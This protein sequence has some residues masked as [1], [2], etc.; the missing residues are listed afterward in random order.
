MKK[1]FYV[2]ILSSVFSCKP[3]LKNPKPSAGDAD[4][5]KF[6]ALGGNFMAG[7]QDWSLNKAGQTYSIP[8]LLAVEFQLAGG[9]I[10]SQPLMPDNSG[11]GLDS[12]TWEHK[13]LKSAYLNYAADCKGVTS[14]MPIVNSFPISSGGIYTAYIGGN[15]QNLSVPF[16]K[17]SDYSSKSFG[18]SG[19]ANP[20][21]ARFAF[22]PGASTMISDAKSLQP[23]FFALWAGME[24]IY[25]SVSVGG[26]KKPIPSS[27]LFSIKL[28]SIL[29]Q[30]NTKGVI[31][32]IPDVSSFPFYTTIPWNGMA[33]TRVLKDSLNMLYF[34]DSL[35]SKNKAL[36]IGNNGFMIADPQDTSHPITGYRQ[37]TNEDYILL[38]VPLD[39]M[40]CHYLGVFTFLP[41][42]YVLTKSEV[43]NINQAI[44]DYN[45][46]I[47]AKAQKYNLAL[48]D[49]NSY[50]KNVV[51]GIKWDG[52]NFNS[53]FVSGGFFSLDGYSPN[54]KGYALIANE[55][56]KAINSKY[57]A[58]IPW[59]NCPECSGVKFP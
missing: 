14:L 26:F 45:T 42:K 31:A 28:D 6:V 30:L 15:F 35:Y 3:N 27:S 1:V 36:H 38:T 9:R 19:N 13:F 29:S 53:Q 24:D 39:S 12:K 51:S 56:I 55:F 20:Y 54:Q 40:K 52:V 33:L 59:V 11:I 43:Q 18:I 44:S 21:Y 23:T 22:N 49:M 25:D 17:I 5:S 46:V 48:V 32:N 34:G 57:N 2:F 58:T 8:A 4:F 10:F 37:M 7:Y 50:F 16:A 47:A 41:D